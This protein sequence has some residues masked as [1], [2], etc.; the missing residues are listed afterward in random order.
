M[1]FQVLP[2]IDLALKAIQ[3]L[4]I[5]PNFIKFKMKSFDDDCNQGLST[6]FALD[7]ANL[8]CSHFI[9]GPSCEYS[10]GK[11]KIITISWNL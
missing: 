6:V 10:V 3:N 2:V 8:E 5:L 4:K 9:I 7:A 11:H 1:L